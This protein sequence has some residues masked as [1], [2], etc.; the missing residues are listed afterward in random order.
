MEKYPSA[1]TLVRLGGPFY[2]VGDL[3][4]KLHVDRPRICAAR[5]NPQNP[6]SREEGEETPFLREQMR[7]KNPLVSSRL[8]L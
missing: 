3:K 5:A 7:K 8:V 1:Q 6:H 4:E 2:L